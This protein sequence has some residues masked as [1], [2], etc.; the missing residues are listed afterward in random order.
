MQ[1][2][3]SRTFAVYLQG[4]AALPSEL[5]LHPCDQPCGAGAYMQHVMCA[6]QDLKEFVAEIKQFKLRM[7]AIMADARQRKGQKKKGGAGRS[8]KQDKQAATAASK[9][10]SVVF[11][12]IWSGCV[13]TMML[14]QSPGEPLVPMSV[15]IIKL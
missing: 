13:V 1:Q 6:S 2:W 3:V 5:W 11:A 14:A 9:W 8:T 7:K 4:S 12:N 10:K 15:P